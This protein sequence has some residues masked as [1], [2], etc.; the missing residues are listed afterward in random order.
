M[1]I[2]SGTIDT[3][4]KLQPLL[5]AIYNVGKQSFT[6]TAESSAPT[7]QNSSI[8]LDHVRTLSPL[9]GISERNMFSTFHN[10]TGMCLT[11]QQHSN[12]GAGRRRRR[13]PR[14]DPATFRAFPPPQIPSGQQRAAAI[15]DI[16]PLPFSHS[17]PRLLQAQR[18]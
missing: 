17:R 8:V 3:T 10:T 14:L 5:K 15:T 7:F 6:H 1:C 2:E 4:V 11:Y 18:D 12:Q 16:R 13:G 9:S